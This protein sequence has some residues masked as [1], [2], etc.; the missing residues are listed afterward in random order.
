MSC[1]PDNQFRKR[2]LSLVIYR[3]A[4]LAAAIKHSSN[5]TARIAPT[6]CQSDQTCLV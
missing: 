2:P 1:T 4:K 3:A 6:I 5:P